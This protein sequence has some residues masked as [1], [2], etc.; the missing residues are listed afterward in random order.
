M[1]DMKCFTWDIII[2]SREGKM[3]PYYTRDWMDYDNVKNDD[4]VLRKYDA[5]EDA[6][7]RQLM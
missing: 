7:K 5:L 4:T 3:T 6:V 2:S 1:I